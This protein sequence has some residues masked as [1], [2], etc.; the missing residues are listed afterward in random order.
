MWNMDIQDNS[1]QLHLGYNTSQGL[2]GLQQPCNE[3]KGPTPLLPACMHLPFIYIYSCTYIIIHN[4]IVQHILS[5]W[6]APLPGLESPHY[7]TLQKMT[8]WHS[9]HLQECHIHSKTRCFNFINI[10]I[11]NLKK[12]V[13][14][15]VGSGPSSTPRWTPQVSG[16]LQSSRRPATQPEIWFDIRSRICQTAREWSGQNTWQC[17][18][19]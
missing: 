15:S 8:P 13:I 4:H 19:S 17:I 18:D 3:E 11:V 14:I 2:Q 1:N 12:W 9:W 7:E 5:Q 6:L 10:D 16:L